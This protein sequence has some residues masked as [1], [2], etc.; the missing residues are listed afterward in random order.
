MKRSLCYLIA[1]ALFSPLARSSA[2]RPHAAV[3]M[4]GWAPTHWASPA[5]QEAYLDQLARSNGL[6]ADRVSA[7]R[8]LAGAQQ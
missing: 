2:A 3:L 7:V 8:D 4:A 5:V 6:A 1:A